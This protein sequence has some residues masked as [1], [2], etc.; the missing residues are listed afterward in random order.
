MQL[1]IPKFLP[2]YAD[3]PQHD[4]TKAFHAEIGPFHRAL[5]DKVVR[6][7][8]VLFAIILELPEEYFVERHAYGR[9]SEDHLRYVSLLPFKDA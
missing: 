9:K 8:M 7:L 1:N 2:E 3:V 4:Y 6:K 5:W